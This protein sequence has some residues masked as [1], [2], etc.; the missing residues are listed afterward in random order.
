MLTVS[1][2]WIALLGALAGL[3]FIL[4]FPFVMAGMVIW[5]ALP[6][7][8]F[9]RIFATVKGFSLPFVEAYL[10]GKKR[11]I[12]K[13]RKEININYPFTQPLKAFE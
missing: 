4:T 12:E 6:K 11:K 10:S 1:I 13:R 7:K 8:A 5:Q 3:A 9:I 2:L